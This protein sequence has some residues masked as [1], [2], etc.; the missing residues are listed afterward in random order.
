MLFLQ[1]GSWAVSL[2]DCVLQELD[3][4]DF[5]SWRDVDPS[6]LGKLVLVKRKKNQQL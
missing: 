2:E 5:F 3:K 4:G 6:F 1:L